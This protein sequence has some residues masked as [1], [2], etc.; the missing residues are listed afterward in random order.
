[1]T[2]LTQQLTGEV[3]TVRIQGGSL[4]I[5]TEP[6]GAVQITLDGHPLKMVRAIRLERDWG[7]GK[8]W[9]VQ[10]DLVRPA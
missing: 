10:I 9:S 3:D 1:M 2:A 5:Q 7:K 4:E 6:S 8:L